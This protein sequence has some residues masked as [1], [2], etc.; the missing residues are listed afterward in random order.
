MEKPPRSFRADLQSLREAAP[1]IFLVLLATVWIAFGFAALCI[2][3][4]GLGQP[5]LLLVIAAAT[6]IALT[7]PMPEGQAKRIAR[8]SLTIASVS[9]LTAVVCG[10][11]FTGEALL[12]IPL[13]TT[14]KTG[15]GFRSAGMLVNDWRAPDGRIPPFAVGVNA[16]NWRGETAPEYRLLSPDPEQ[17]GEYGVDDRFTPGVS[18][19]KAGVIRPSVDELKDDNGVWVER[20]W[21]EDGI[22]W[23]RDPFFLTRPEVILAVRENDGKK[24]SLIIGKGNRAT[25]GLWR[26]EADEARVGDR[27]ARVI[28]AARWDPGV[29]LTMVAWPFGLVG[30][31]LCLAAQRRRQPRTEATGDE[32]ATP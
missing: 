32:T 1:V 22:I 13:T 4:N 16:L 20:R 6:A 2:D 15:D 9:L 30:A 19:E 21:L 24:Q 28:V 18:P 14:Q 17:P 8:F 3:D 27:E 5:A 23:E 25:Y 7:L 10:M 29:A 26:I 12:E 31:S 11:H